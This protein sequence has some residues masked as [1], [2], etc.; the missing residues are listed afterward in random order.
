MFMINL[1]GTAAVRIVVKVYCSMKKEAIVMNDFIY[2]YPTKVYFGE[3]AASKALPSE[4]AKA[5]KTVSLPTA[6]VPLLTAVRL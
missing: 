1:A 2:S 4:L 6:A 5:G 3:K